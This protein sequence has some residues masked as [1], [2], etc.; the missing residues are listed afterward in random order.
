MLQ[1]GGLIDDLF[2][3]LMKAVVPVATTGAKPSDNLRYTKSDKDV[4][5]NSLKHDVTFLLKENQEL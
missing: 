5:N 4:S 3:N 2:D 1:S